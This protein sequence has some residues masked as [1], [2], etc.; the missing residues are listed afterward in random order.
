MVE[1]LIGFVLSVVACIAGIY[2]GIA[3]RKRKNAKESN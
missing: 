2:A 1:L 3:L